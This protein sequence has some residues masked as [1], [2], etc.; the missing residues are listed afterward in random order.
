VIRDD[1]PDARE[2]QAG[3][4]GVAERFGVQASTIHVVDCPSMGEIYVYEYHNRPGFRVIKPGDWSHAIGGKDFPTLAEAMNVAAGQIIN[5]G[6]GGET[7]SS[8]PTPAGD[9][10]NNPQTMTLDVNNHSNTVDLAT[11]KITSTGTIH[12]SDA[13]FEKVGR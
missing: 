12:G 13:I 8:T 3:R 11:N 10:S 6:P 7:S 1:Q 4:A 2:G 9:G 5:A